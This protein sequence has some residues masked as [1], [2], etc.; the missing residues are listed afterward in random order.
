MNYSLGSL[1]VEIDV[2][3]NV[4]GTILQRKEN[5]VW[6]DYVINGGPVINPFDVEKLPPGFYRLVEPPASIAR[7]RI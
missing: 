7:D 4:P 1:G 3:R 2:G 5:N 6:Y